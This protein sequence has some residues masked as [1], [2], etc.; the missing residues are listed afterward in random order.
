M[1]AERFEALAFW[2]WLPQ[3]L[4]M[5]DLCPTRLISID[6]QHDSLRSMGGFLHWEP[7]P[8]PLQQ[9]DLETPRYRP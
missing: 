6:Q 8:P 4:F 1:V 9:T 7:L 2:P 3:D 5:D